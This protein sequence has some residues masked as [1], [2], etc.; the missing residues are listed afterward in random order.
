M[1]VTLHLINSSNTNASPISRLLGSTGVL[2]KNVISHS[3]IVDAMHATVGAITVQL[4][5]IAN[6]GRG[7]EMSKIDI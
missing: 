4:K 7:I 5:E 1:G 6:V 2:R 3:L